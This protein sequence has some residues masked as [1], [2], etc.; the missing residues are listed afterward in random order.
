MFT[1]DNAGL[2]VGLG[3]N[4][5]FGKTEM[6]YFHRNQLK[7]FQTFYVVSRNRKCFIMVDIRVRLVVV[8]SV[9]TLAFYLIHSFS[10]RQIDWAYWDT[11]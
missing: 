4:A 7:H 10:K 9:R 2:D 1:K 6:P 11:L 8:K 5:V 3:F